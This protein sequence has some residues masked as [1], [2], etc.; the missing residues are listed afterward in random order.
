M[1]FVT[2]QVFIS[3]GPKTEIILTHIHEST[4]VVLSGYK[5][6]SWYMYNMGKPLASKFKCCH[7]EV[8]VH[9]TYSDVIVKGSGGHCTSCWME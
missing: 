7:S 4:I 9:C 5:I 2:R 6:I 8:H 1:I 3:E